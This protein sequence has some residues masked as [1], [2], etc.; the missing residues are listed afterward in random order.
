MARDGSSVWDVFDGRAHS[1]RMGLHPLEAGEWARLPDA[2][3]LASE[4]DRRAELL[5]TRRE[6]VFLVL[7]EPEA[8]QAGA[9][10][11]DRLVSHLV[12]RHR[13]RYTRTGDVLTLGDDG[14][15]WPLDGSRPG[16][17]VAGRLVTEDWCLVR[18]GAPPILA[19]GVVCSPNRWRLAEKLGRPITE[20]HD[21]VPGYRER[22]GPPVDGVLAG[23][24]ARVWRRNWS[25]QSSP[26]RFQPVADGPELPAV[27]AE[28]WVRS[29]HETLVR[30]P[31]SGWWVFGI[32]TSIR[33][34]RDV[35]TDPGLARRIATAVAA[36]DHATAAYKDLAPW[37]APLLAW[38]EAVAAPASPPTP[39]RQDIL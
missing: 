34:L 19:G 16:L 38:L 25:I 13:D 11:A 26:S 9:E 36:L 30:L 17:E 31:S 18:P 27:P 12:E 3:D 35:Q 29:E 7:D 24:R 23:P 33:P 37:R 8:A 39:S 28:A 5:D 2:P 4:L 6:Q 21:P 32:Q 15:A 20:V 14:R 10:L 1:L 22:L